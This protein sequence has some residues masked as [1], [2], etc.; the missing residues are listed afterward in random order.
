MPAT[1]DTPEPAEDEVPE[2][3]LAKPEQ[4]PL[5][6]TPAKPAAVATATPARP[7]IQ[8]EHVP[9]PETPAV[10]QPHSPAQHH[11]SDAVFET[12]KKTKD[13]A[14]KSLLNDEVSLEANLSCS[15]LQLPRWY[16]ADHV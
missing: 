2:I 5:P 11:A 4:V 6:S 13:G 15:K 8:A 12:P 9:L 14:E 1:A 16:G 7:A 3:A 10:V